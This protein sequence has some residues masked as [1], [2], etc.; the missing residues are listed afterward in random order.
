MTPSS[1][2]TRNVTA[3][4]AVP[5]ESFALK[6]NVKFPTSLDAGV[7]LNVRVDALKDN[8]DGVLFEIV[9]D[10]EGESYENVEG[11]KV[12]EKGWETTARGGTCAFTGKVSWGIDCTNGMNPS[13]EATVAKIRK[14]MLLARSNL[15]S[16][17]S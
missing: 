12:N 6:V 17:N 16:V 11:E 3:P 13:R 9:Y 4:E 15:S 5:V 1:C 14:V 10:I 7:P 8:H 2:T